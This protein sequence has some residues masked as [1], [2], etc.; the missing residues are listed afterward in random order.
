MR[1]SVIVFS[2]LT[3]LLITG[4]IYYITNKKIE[5]YTEPSDT[6]DTQTKIPWRPPKELRAIQ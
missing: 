3:I 6:P 4:L 5:K 2:L 1:I